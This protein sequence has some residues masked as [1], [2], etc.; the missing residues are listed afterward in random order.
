[1]ATISED[2]V[3]WYY[4]SSNYSKERPA[5]VRALTGVDRWSADWG[6]AVGSGYRVM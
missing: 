3:I 4:L 1:M 2:L 5:G 6:I